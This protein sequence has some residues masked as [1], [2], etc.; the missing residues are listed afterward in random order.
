MATSSVDLL[1]MLLILSSSV[2]LTSTKLSSR[3]VHSC[4]VDIVSFKEKDSVNVT[5]IHSFNVNLN[6]QRIIAKGYLRKPVLYYTKSTSTYQIHR[7]IRLSNDIKENPGPVKNPCSV[8]E[9][10]VAKNHR[11][12]E[13]DTCHLKCH[14]AC[15]MLPLS[16]Y[17]LILS[18]NTAWICPCC[19]M[20][21]LP[22]QMFDLDPVDVH[23]PVQE[24]GFLST[25]DLKLLK[26]LK[27]LNLNVQSLYPKIDDIK[28][29]CL[30]CEPDILGITESWLNDSISNSEIHIPNYNIYR[31]DRADGYGGVILYTHNRLDTNLITLSQ[32]TQGK[33]DTIWV[34]LALPFSRS[35]LVGI[36]YGPKVSLEYFDE[37]DQVMSEIDSLSV[38]SNTPDEILCI[39]DYN[40]DALKPHEWEWRKINSTMAKHH[41][42]QIITVPTRI[43]QLSKS[44]IDHVWTNRPE[45]YKN[46][47]AI[48]FPQSDHQLVYAAR[49]S[50]RL[51]KGTSRNIRARSYRN[52]SVSAFLDDLDKAPW[53]T[54]EA[55]DNPDMAWDIF[56]NLFISICDKHAPFKNMKIP[57]NP[58]PWFNDDYLS[59]RRDLIASKSRAEK[60]KLATDWDIFR[61][62][63]NKLNNMSKELKRSYFES[64]IKDAGNDSRRL[65]K[66]VK[67]IIPGS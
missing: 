4:L 37:L 31:K 51:A 20:L 15:G 36:I 23:L 42:T 17:R 13:C 59:L 22:T 41:L 35:V 65:W 9:R 67:T 24:D 58:P 64:A 44:C 8:C 21:E 12:L 28:L 1:L 47:G 50:P 27:I 18:Q 45:M 16:D 19:L 52:F 53:H 3:N 66:T 60:S 39:G 33:I 54:V 38:S 29:L 11:N 48:T 10:P 14:F 32:S 34:K 57:N 30:E 46:N 61:A 63:R 40:C 56:Q 5:T 49:K 55:C 6:L 26:G 62:I 2:L 43:T 25:I 7:V